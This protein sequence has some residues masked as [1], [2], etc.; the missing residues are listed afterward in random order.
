VALV[1]EDIDHPEQGFKTQD[2]DEGLGA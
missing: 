2:M 1:L